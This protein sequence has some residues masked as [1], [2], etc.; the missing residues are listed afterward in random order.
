[1]ARITRSL[2]RVAP[3]FAFC[4]AVLVGEASRAQQPD[5]LLFT[6]RVAPNVMFILDNSGSMNNVVWHPGLP[7]GCGLQHD[8][9]SRY[10]ADTSSPSYNP[11]CLQYDLCSI[12]TS[13]DLLGTEGSWVGDEYRLDWDDDGGTITRCG[14]TRELYPDAEVDAVQRDTAWDQNYLRWYFSDNAD[15]VYS[16]IVATNNGTTSS[17]LGTPTS[18]GLYRRARVTAA[19]DVTNQVICE[20]AGVAELRYGLA[21]F[22][23]GSDPQ[24][25]YVVVPMANYT[26]AHGTTMRNAISQIEGESMTPLSE[27][28]Y[29]VYKYFMLRGSTSSNRPFGKDGSTRFPVYD[30]ETD[31]DVNSSGAPANPVTDTCQKHFVVMITD[32]EPHPG[33]PRRSLLRHRLPEARS[34]HLGRRP[35]RRLLPARR[36]VR[37]RLHRLRLRGVALPRRRRVLHAHAGLPAHHQPRRHPDARRLHGGLHHQRRGQ[38]HPQPR[39]A[40][41]RRRVLQQQQ[42]AGA[43]RC[44]HQLDR[45]HRR[46]VAGVH[47]RRR[48]GQPHHQ[49]RQLLLGLLRAGA[50]LADLGRA[51]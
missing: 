27:T 40:A 29:N 13:D 1:M 48:A 7:P 35:D 5:T 19:K 51:T 45:Q 42:P 21:K 8:D 25:G 4:A 22:Y 34:D 3:L 41:R 26:A 15:A 46:Q 49:R 28:L 10:V 23:D 9:V 30:L 31:G 37:A 47:L 33:R 2:T 36:R 17:C 11:L 14:N 18:F 44:D 16:D 38:R 12:T 50:R 20:T 32:G 24:G 6:T 43:G 39:R